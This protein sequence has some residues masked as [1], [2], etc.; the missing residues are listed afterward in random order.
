MKSS[1]ADLTRG[2]HDS[3]SICVQ[4]GGSSG[5]PLPS[6]SMWNY[7]LCGPQGPNGGYAA[8][9]TAR[10]AH[11]AAPAASPTSYSLGGESGADAP[12]EIADPQYHSDRVPF[13]QRSHHLQYDWPYQRNEEQGQQ[14]PYVNSY[15]PPYES[16]PPAHH[17]RRGPGQK[18]SPHYRRANMAHGRPMPIVAQQR[19]QQ[20]RYL[21]PLASDQN[22]MYYGNQAYAEPLLNCPSPMQKEYQ[23]QNI[24]LPHTPQAHPQKH[25]HAAAAAPLARQPPYSAQP[26]HSVKQPH[27]PQKPLAGRSGNSAAMPN[28]WSGPRKRTPQNALLGLFSEGTIQ[29]GDRT[30]LFADRNGVPYE[31]EQQQQQRQQELGYKA[32]HEGVPFGSDNS[33]DH[34]PQECQASQ[35]GSG[36]TAALEFENGEYS[37]VMPSTLVVGQRQRQPGCPQ[38]VHFDPA[39]A[40][41]TLGEYFSDDNGPIRMNCDAPHTPQS[42]HA[43]QHRD[44]APIVTVGDM[45]T[46]QPQHVASQDVSRTPNRRAGHVTHYPGG[47]SGSGPSKKPML[48]HSNVSGAITSREANESGSGDSSGGAGMTQ[49][50][51]VG[52]GTGAPAS[53]SL[54][55]ASSA[56]AA[57]TT[58]STYQRYPSTNN[59]VIRSGDVYP[60]HLERRTTTSVAATSSS[61]DGANES[62]STSNA[63]FVPPLPRSAGATDGDTAME[64]RPPQGQAVSTCAPLKGQQH[65]Q[66][67]PSECSSAT[68]ESQTTNDREDYSPH[69]AAPIKHRPIIPSVNQPNQFDGMHD[70]QHQPEEQYRPPSER[71]NTGSDYHGHVN[72]T[73][74]ACR[75]SGIYAQGASVSRTPLLNEDVK[76]NTAF[77]GS[78]YDGCPMAPSRERRKKANAG[79]RGA[80]S[81]QTPGISA[82]LTQQQQRW[83]MQTH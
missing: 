45:V 11:E 54:G 8:L 73:S 6:T 68:G 83:R 31:D 37:M 77:S 2:T 66:R 30:H 69:I 51:N 25:T 1:M 57:V 74:E 16:Q 22:A 35:Q 34:I 3:M 64:H 78:P 72:S 67:H 17:S 28:N 46:P 70:S 19:R 79:R 14:M 52:G 62:R 40:P 21:Y 15:A 71:G 58:Y 36:F 33:L 10:C 29:L 65:Q 60:S 32:R 26:R 13:E 27:Y 7:F 39:P 81:M 24:P 56:A 82:P 61:Q 44:N 75:I 5:K 4:G 20:G 38:S 9:P 12:C 47:S 23:S 55:G 49:M 43:D 48:T 41:H 50:Y 80:R 59:Y 76:T 42:Q 18:S 63:L 53:T